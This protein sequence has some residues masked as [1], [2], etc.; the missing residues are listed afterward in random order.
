MMSAGGA[1][2]PLSRFCLP[3]GIAAG[4]FSCNDESTFADTRSYDS[5]NAALR[6]GSSSFPNSLTIFPI[7]HTYPGLPVVSN[8]DVIL[9]TTA[10]ATGR[11]ADPKNVNPCRMSLVTRSEAS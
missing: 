8:E 3:S 2:F 6:L 4:D 5:L 10:E 7:I 11:A 1:R 9:E